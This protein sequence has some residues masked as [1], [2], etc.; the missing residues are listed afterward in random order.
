MQKFTH[1]HLFRVGARERERERESR[2]TGYERRDLSCWLARARARAR[3]ARLRILCARLVAR[4]NTRKLRRDATHARCISTRKQSHRALTSAS[5][6]V[7][8]RDR[9]AGSRIK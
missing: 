3:L 2:A 5:A 9:R 1:A 4:T 7:R 8:A 6:H